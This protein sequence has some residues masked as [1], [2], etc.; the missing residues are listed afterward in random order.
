MKTCKVVVFERIDANQL[1][2]F[3]IVLKLVTLP[4]IFKILLLFLHFCLLDKS[5]ILSVKNSG[6]RKLPAYTLPCYSNEAEN[7]AFR[8]MNTFPAYSAQGELILFI[9]LAAHKCG[10]WENW[11]GLL[12]WTVRFPGPRLSRTQHL[13]LPLSTRACLEVLGTERSCRGAPDT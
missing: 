3:W 1:M 8:T 2:L 13:V 5:R 4:K 7:F 12:G 9:H 11:T 10:S 6:E